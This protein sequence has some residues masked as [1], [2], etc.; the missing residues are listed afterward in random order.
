M[1]LIL[2]YTML[3]ILPFINEAAVKM[4]FLIKL[5]TKYNTSLPFSDC[6]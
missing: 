5:T 4:I 1:L 2:L 6:Y 3:L